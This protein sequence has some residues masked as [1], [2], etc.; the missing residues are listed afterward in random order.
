MNTKLAELELELEPTV[1]PAHYC[2]SCPVTGPREV[3][4]YCSINAP[5]PGGGWGSLSQNLTP[6][7]VGRLHTW[8][9]WAWAAGGPPIGDGSHLW[10]SLC[11][12]GSSQ[13]GLAIHPCSRNRTV[14]E[15]S[16]EMGPEKRESTNTKSGMGKQTLQILQMGR[17]SS[18]QDNPHEHWIPLSGTRYFIWQRDL[19]GGIEDLETGRVSCIRRWAWTMITS[20][21]IRRRLDSEGGWWQRQSPDDALWRWEKWPEAEECRWPPRAGKG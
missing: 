4:F 13:P 19:A 2:W 1:C 10:I 11:T 5:R 16:E 18:R 6:T 3:L 14:G 17:G 9:E 21:L 20:I 15:N 7:Q 12:R 8:A